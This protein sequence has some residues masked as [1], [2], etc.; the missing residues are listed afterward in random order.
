MLLAE[1]QVHAEAAVR[2]RGPH[3]RHAAQLRT[4]GRPGHPPSGSRRGS[5]WTGRGAPGADGPGAAAAAG[6]SGRSW[7]TAVNELHSM[8]LQAGARRPGLPPSDDGPRRGSGDGAHLPGQLSTCRRAS[9]RSRSVGARTSGWRHA[10]GNPGRSTDTGRISKCGD[11]MMRA[12]LYEAAHSLCSRE[13][14][15]GRG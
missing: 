5:A 9:A 14:R 11:A 1:P 7:R 3:P 4:E 13:R 6:A 2:R 15:G 8:M 12:A 10:N